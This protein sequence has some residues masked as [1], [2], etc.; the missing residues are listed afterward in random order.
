[1]LK[2]YWRIRMRWHQRRSTALFKLA[3]RTPSRGGMMN[4]IERLKH[5]AALAETFFRKIKG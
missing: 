4:I 1:M 3:C 2:V 5:H